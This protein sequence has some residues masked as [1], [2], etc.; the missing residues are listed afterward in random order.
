M[1]L[2]Y[3]MWEKVSIIRVAQVFDRVQDIAN[4]CPG[5]ECMARQG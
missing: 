5:H 3:G 4:H 2:N 1:K